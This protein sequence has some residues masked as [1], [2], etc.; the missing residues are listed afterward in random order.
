MATGGKLGATTPSLA[1]ALVW[2]APP[3]RC[4]LGVII[5]QA[6]KADAEAIERAIAAIRA[7]RDANG[8]R[9]STGPNSR[10]LTERLQANGIAVTRTGVQAH[11]AGRC[12]CVKAT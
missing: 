11:V 4:R 7:N 12:A 3:A 5:D 1:D 2:T 9:I 8:T 6:D 10:W